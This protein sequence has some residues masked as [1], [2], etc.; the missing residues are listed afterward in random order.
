[1]EG[2]WLEL[3]G[4][5]HLTGQQIVDGLKPDNVTDAPTL[6]KATDGQPPASLIQGSTSAET[7]GPFSEYSFGRF[8]HLGLIAFLQLARRQ[9]S[10][11]F[12]SV[13]NSQDTPNELKGCCRW[14]R[15]VRGNGW[16]QGREIPMCGAGRSVT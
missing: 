15:I 1:M 7:F 2:L 6:K 13:S 11:Y 16:K 10:P 9:V 3:I 8:C 5:G 14:R 4:A 12:R